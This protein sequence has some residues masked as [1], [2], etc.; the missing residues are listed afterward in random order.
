V[1][2]ITDDKV[3][4][5]RPVKTGVEDGDRVQILAGVDAGDQ[6]AVAGHGQLRD[7]AKVRA[8]GEPG[9]TAESTRDRNVQPS[10]AAASDTSP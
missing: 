9:D 6:V 10:E 2:V 3:A 1:F 4:H 8:V 5:R 7:G